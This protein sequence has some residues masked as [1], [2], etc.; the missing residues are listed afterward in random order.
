MMFVGLNHDRAR[1]EREYFESAY[2]DYARQNP[3][4]KLRFYRRLVEDALGGICRPAIVE[5]GCGLGS[6]L[7]S[8]DENWTKFGCD[9]SAY[10]LNVARS[11]NPS[12]H[13]VLA[14]GAGLP[15][16]RE[17]DAVVSFDVL[18]HVPDVAR[19]F[20]EVA[21]HLAPNGVFVFVV[22]VYDG[23]SGPIIRRFDRDPTHLY[24]CG[25]RFWLDLSRERFHVVDWCGVV[26]YLLPGGIYLNWPTRLLRHHAPAVAIVA[27]HKAH[28][29]NGAPA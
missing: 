19:A 6:F 21:A 9:V 4:W 24:K 20:D 1:F 16:T 12:A 2:R 7:A 10:A 17:F 29:R 27:R 22:P 28:A 15:F 8:L 11:R 5:I 3:S 25:R 13:F 26:R 14:S 18:E 23:L